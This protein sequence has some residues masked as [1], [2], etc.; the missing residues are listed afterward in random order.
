MTD[1]MNTVNDE[2]RFSTTTKIPEC[3]IKREDYFHRK[4]VFKEFARV[5]GFQD[6][7]KK[8]GNPDMPESEFLYLLSDDKTRKN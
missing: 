4:F 2:D 5:K 1:N 3:D 8:V 7:L 6:S